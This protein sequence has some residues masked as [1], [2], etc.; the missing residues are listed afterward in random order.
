VFATAAIPGVL[1][2]VAL[3][4]NLTRERGREPSAPAPAI[5]S[6]P[7]TN[8]PV[9]IRHPAGPPL[10]ATSQTNLAGQMVSVSCVSCH[11]T[12]TPNFNTRDAADLKEFHQGLNYNHASLSCLSCHNPN[13]YDTLRL[14]DGTSVPFTDVMQLCAQCHGPQARDYR[15]GA[16]GGMT[17]F[18]DLQRG[19]RQ[20]NNCIDCHDAHA[21]Q[22]PQVMPVFTPRDGPR[23]PA[24]P[25]GKSHSLI[26]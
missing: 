17:G 20:R 3:G 8:W 9:S 22:Y 2:V 12:T 19:G 11:A 15:N 18:W 10:V 23:P 7:A 25:N 26:P 4:S 1:V 13:D 21:P 16:H 5:A 6:A 24:H 14:A